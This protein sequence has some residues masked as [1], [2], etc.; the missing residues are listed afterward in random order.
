VMAV[1]ATDGMLFD[2]EGNLWMGGL[3]NNA[4]NQLANNGTLYRVVQDSSLKW[5]D[6]FSQM[7]DGEIYFTTSQ[8][9]L[10][11]EERTAYKV[12]K[13]Q[14]ESIENKPL[15]KILIAI[16]SHG[17]LGENEGD[18]TGYYLSEVSHAYY[19][20]KEA[21]FQVE[22]TS[23]KGGESPIDGYNLK[24]PYNKRFVNDSIAQH[25]INNA[26]PAKQITPAHYRAIYF[27]GGHGTMWD[28]PENQALQTA[29]RKIYETGGIVSAVCHGPAGLV[30]IQ[31]SN[32]TYL[33]SNRRMAAF[34]NEEEEISGLTETVPFLLQSKLEERG[35]TVLTGEPYQQQV[36]VDGRLVTGQNPASAKKAAEKIVELLTR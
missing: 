31:L 1:P 5:V 6:S 28:F 33:V 8:I 14:P 26:L 2:N 19:V 4:I 11:V 17:T 36:V 24:D 29:S 18:S 15:N 30:N 23:P 10:P 9:H 27:A 13:L 21:G 25:A 20:F 7:G 32:D 16:T 34:T 12:M 35:A 3:E 22:F